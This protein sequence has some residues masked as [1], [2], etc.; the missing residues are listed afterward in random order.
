MERDN[1]DVGP[2]LDSTDPAYLDTSIISFAMMEHTLFHSSSLAYC[3]RLIA[4]RVVV[5]IAEIHTIEILQALVAIG[6]DPKQV[7]GSIR[8]QYRLHRWGDE[9]HVRRR[10]LNDG[11]QRYQA[12]LKRFASV[13]FLE[14][15]GPV[16][17][18]TVEYMARF[19]LKSAD[20]MHLALANAAQATVLVTADRDYEA[21]AGQTLVRID[22]IR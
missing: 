18:T 19:K 4:E 6:N 10:W 3:E 1:G 21:A 20:A 17:L 14:V 9:E 11:F 7:Q 12:F 22:I 16:R 8:R 15:T 2:E 5:M 13:V